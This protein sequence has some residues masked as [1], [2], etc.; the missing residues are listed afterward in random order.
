M[1]HIIQLKLNKFKIKF[2]HD[3]QG[4]LKPIEKFSKISAI[5]IH[6]EMTFD[7]FID[8]F[9]TRF[10]KENDY[11]YEKINA[12]TRS[13]GKEKFISPFKGITDPKEKEE[14][15]QELIKKFEN[16]MKFLG[17]GIFG[18]VK[19]YQPGV[20]IKIEKCNFYY[21]LWRKSVTKEEM[22]IDFPQYFIKKE[23]EKE[24][25]L[26]P[27]I[28]AGLAPEIYEVESCG[29]KCITFMEEIKG[30]TIQNIIDKY[31]KN[32]SPE[33]ERIKAREFSNEGFNIYNRREIM[34]K[35]IDEKTKKKVINLA[36]KVASAVQKFHEIMIKNGHEFGHGD[37][38]MHNVMITYGN[39]N[40]LQE[41]SLENFPVDLN[42]MDKSQ[43]IKLIDF[44]F[45]SK[46][47]FKDDWESFFIHFPFKDFGISSE[48][49]EDLK[50]SFIKSSKYPKGK[51]FLKKRKEEL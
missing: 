41:I 16:D 28:D 7:N 37:L 48:I 29:N 35:V 42:L 25:I 34:S 14:K 27:V 17:E 51:K 20:A 5:S 1:S 4:N 32:L 33:D 10:E 44:N 23:R 49:E 11:S 47:E 45:E 31:W 15:C 2:F 46:K 18:E 38:K 43:E 19:I 22:E 26:K 8:E 50:T 30:K 24:E 40:R 13:K 12:N 39:N 36:I 3:G 9:L 6:K 21:L